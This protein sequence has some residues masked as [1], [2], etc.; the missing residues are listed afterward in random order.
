[1]LN[2]SAGWHMHLDILAARASGKEPQPFW[3]GF[4]RLK[5]EYGRLLPAD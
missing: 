3:D 1:M 5:T 4:S 2:V